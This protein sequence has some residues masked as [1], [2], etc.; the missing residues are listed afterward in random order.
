M[1]R[2]GHLLEACGEALEAC[3]AVRV[4]PLLVRSGGRLLRGEGLAEVGV[5]AHARH[6][7]ME[8]RGRP[9]GGRGMSWDAEGVRGR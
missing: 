7:P 3:V 9:R 2:G 5:E 8:G 6:L 1:R 4:D